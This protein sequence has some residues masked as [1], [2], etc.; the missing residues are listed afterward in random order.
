MSIC[1][2]LVVELPSQSF[3]KPFLVYVSILRSRNVVLGQVFKKTCTYPNIAEHDLA[4]IRP[5]IACIVHLISI[6]LW[7]FQKYFFI[8]LMNRNYNCY[9]Y[10]QGHV[11]RYMPDVSYLEEGSDL[12]LTY[13]KSVWVWLVEAILIMALIR[14]DFYTIFKTFEH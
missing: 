12:Y 2:Y 10:L 7:I 11:D 9:D 3:L 1:G 8:F 14:N 5:Y 6:L 4:C 13:K